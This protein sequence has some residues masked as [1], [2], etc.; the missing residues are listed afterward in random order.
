CRLIMFTPR[1]TPSSG[2]RQAPRTGGRK[3]VS[4]AQPGLLFSPRRSAVTARSTPTRVQGHAAL[5]SHHFDIQTFGSSLPVKVMEALTMADVDDQISV[6]VEASGW[7]WMVCGEQLIIWKVSQ[8]SV[9]KLSVCKD[10]QLP[11]S[12]FVYS[13]DLISITSSRALA[14][15]PDGSARFWPSLAHDGTYTETSLDLAGNVCNYVA[16]VKVFSLAV[17]GREFHRVIVPRSPGFQP[18]WHPRPAGRHHGQYCLF[19]RGV[20]RSCVQSVTG[21]LAP[22]VFSVLWVKETGCLYSLSSCGL[23]KW[24]VDE[25]SETQVL[26]WSTNQIITDS[27]TDAIWDSESNYSEI[28]KGVNVSYLDMQYTGLVVLAAAWH[29]GDTPCVAYFCLVTLAE[30]IAPSPDLLTV[31][32]TKYNPPF[33]SEEELQKTRVVLPEPSS[34]AAYL[35]NEELVFTCSTGAGRG[36]LA[37]E[38]ISFSSPGDRIRGGGVCAGLP[39]F[40][41]QNSGLVAVL[42]RESASLLPETM[43]DSLC[44]SVAGPEGTPLETPPKIDSVAQEDKTKLLKQAF[45]Q[46]CRHDLVGA[47]SMVDELFPSDGEGSAELDAVVT[48]IDLDLV[49]DYPACDPRWAESVPDEGA[50]FTLTSLILLHQLEDKMKAHRCLMDFLLQTGLLDRLASTTVR[51]SPMATRLL[52]CEH[53]EKLSAAIVLKNHHAKHPELVNTAILSALKKSN[54]DILTNLTPADVF[55]REVSQISSIFECLLDEEE[56]AL[57][58]HSDSARWAEVVLN[59]NDIVKD[60]LQAAAQYR[61]TKASLYRAPENCG[62]EPEYIPWT[63]SGG[64]GGVRTVITRQHELILR[65]AYPHADV[66][67]RGM[68]SEQLVALLDSLLSGYVAQLTSLRRAGQQERYVTLENEYTQKRSELLAPLLELG[69]H[70]WVAA[71]AEKY[72]DFDIL[73]QLCER[74]ENQSRLQQ[75]MVKFADQNFADFLF[76]WYMEKGKRGKLLSQPVATHQQ[77]A[78]FLQAHDHL[79]WLHDIHVQDYQRAHRTLYSQANME[80]RYFSKKKTLLALSKLTALAS[81]MPENKKQ[82]MHQERFQL[83]QETLPKQLLDEKQLNPDSMPLLSPRNLINLYICDENRGANEYDFK[84]ALDLLEYLEEV[85]VNNMLKS[86]F[87]T[88]S[89]SDDNDDPLEAARDSTFVKILQKLIQEGVSLQS[90]LPDVKDLLQEDELESLKSKPYFEFLLRANY[91]HYQKAQI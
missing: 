85:S 53:A 78:S 66:E 52:L 64:A 3:S 44:T 84:K 27:I 50:G 90:Y 72:C 62:P 28:K 42:A 26:S 49:D 14:V 77:L 68:L 80:T 15:S 21:R 57:K 6:K 8:T 34:P 31:E 25:N 2:R 16:A 54:T 4:A 20:S 61:E 75:Y 22:Q 37:E 5:D 32:V 41:S 11:S 29:P 12:E 83:H 43:E 65:V 9:A 45:L 56:K 86:S 55:F 7:A 87:S 82:M 60:M 24:E 51:M 73:V 81:D 30:S 59:V 36:G 46:F 10:L 74:T 13:A 38:K 79:S 71:L 58:E 19:F 1:G 69:Q 23:S 48:Q 40:F 88:W 89:S 70:Q 76:R 47:Q 63:A 67:L 18:V 91:E 33:Q 35:Y 17:S 39:V